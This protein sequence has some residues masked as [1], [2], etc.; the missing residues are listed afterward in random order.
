MT[1]LALME[2]NVK[3][4][5]PLFVL[6]CRLLLRI[7]QTFIKALQGYL[8]IGTLPAHIIK[9]EKL[10]NET[11]WDQERAGEELYEASCNGDLNVVEWLCAKAPKHLANGF[12]N[13]KGGHC[14]LLPLSAAAFHGHLDIMEFLVSNG[15]R[16]NEKGDE[17]RTALHEAA[18]GGHLIVVQWLVAND[19]KVNVKDTNG[20]TPLHR[21]ASC[22]HFPVVQWLVC[23][24]SSLNE[25][26]NIG[27]TPLYAAASTGKLAVVQWLAANGARINERNITG[28]TAMNAAASMGHLDVVQWLVKEG[29]PVNG[30]DNEKRTALFAA[31][32]M[33][34]L[35]VVQ[36]LVDNG[37]S[38]FNKDVSDRTVLHVAAS[39]LEGNLSVIDFLTTEGLEPFDRDKLGNTA[40]HYAV[41]GHRYEIVYLFLR[42][43]QNRMPPKADLLHTLFAAARAD[44]VGIIQ[45]LKDKY[46]ADIC[47]VNTQGRTML[48]QA[49]VGGAINVVKLLLDVGVEIDQTDHFG[50]TPMIEA[51]RNGQIGVVRRFLD[52][53]ASVSTAN[54]AGR[55]VLHYAAGYPELTTMLLNYGVHIDSCDKRGWTPLHCAAAAGHLE[56]VKILLENGAKGTCSTLCSKTAMVLAIERGYSDVVKYFVECTTTEDN[57]PVSSKES[58]ETLAGCEEYILN[59]TDVHFDS[60]WGVN[61][62]GTWLDSPIEVKVKKHSYSKNVVEELSRWSKLNHPHV[63]KLYGICYSESISN[64]FFVYERPTHGSLLEYIADPRNAISRLEIWR[65]LYEAALG[66]QYLHDRDLVHGD[67]RC[68][69]IVITE[70]GV[71][72][73]RNLGSDHC[74][75]PAWTAPEVLSGFPRSFESDIYAFGI[76]II[77]AILCV[78]DPWDL[79]GVGLEDTILSGFLPDKPVDMTPAQWQL[80][81]RMCSYNPRSRLSAADVARELELLSHDHSNS[82]TGYNPCEM[83][84]KLEDLPGFLEG[85]DDEGERE[86]VLTYL[87]FE[88]SKYLTYYA[89]S[90]MSTIPR[91][92][93][94]IVALGVTKNDWFI[95]AYEVEFDQFDEFSRGA[96]GKVYHG[97]WKRSDVVVKKVELK[98]EGDQAAFLN[99]VKIWFKLFHPHVV[100]LFG[101]CHIG[102]PFF[103][104]E[105]AGRG[106]LDAYLRRH[107]E[108][109]YERLYEAALGLRYLRVKQV[110]HG[111]LKCNNILIGSDGRAKLTDFGLSTTVSKEPEEDP[112]D[113]GNLGAIRWKAPE[114]L[115]G[116]KA[117]FASD[118][119]SFGM[120][121]LEA[122]SG[123]YPWGVTLD[124]V[125]KYYVLKLKKLPQRPSNCTEATYNLVERMCRYEPSARTNIDQVIAELSAL[126]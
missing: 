2:E 124:P 82:L 110:V 65:K 58:A 64:P 114:V 90:A 107:P 44:E 37:A 51:C 32:S 76:T 31:A 126:R 60:S 84:K 49:A 109:L 26:N 15:A 74:Y 35:P 9:L 119:Y 59:P 47:H 20:W 30:K 24:G 61:I 8:S 72:K 80:V 57:L 56:T 42:D 121:I 111:D 52:A 70:D 21:A 40:M 28:Q 54:L 66:L 19:S 98:D 22:G 116:E 46:Q 118:I 6:V 123:T 78:W 106:Q 86:E 48:H 96:F 69:S 102:Q 97:K 33:G 77:Q 63:V 83:L 1:T 100:H 7:A 18:T 105:Y 38:L 5:A 75:R 3:K 67:I 12:V 85:I 11:G 104:C 29:A 92:K 71:A 14:R 4:L 41:T 117:T 93:N 89:T 23:Q 81:E 88:L 68:G 94:A 10:L 36:R 55:T 50:S 91:V 125:V 17:G 113:N 39:T 95:P 108:Y 115:R 43:F 73:L 53:G 99:E 34:H 45:L 103:V 16:I 101:A 25:K 79:D 112:K 122:A 13:G 27:Q 62:S 87:R 120:C